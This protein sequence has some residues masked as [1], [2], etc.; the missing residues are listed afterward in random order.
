MRIRNDKDIVVAQRIRHARNN[1]E[2][3]KSLSVEDASNGWIWNVF[4]RAFH[5]NR[6][7]ARWSSWKEKFATSKREL[8]NTLWTSVAYIHAIVFPIEPDYPA[9]LCYVTA[10]RSRETSA[11]GKRLHARTGSR[12][13]VII[14]KASSGSSRAWRW[15]VVRMQIKVIYNGVIS[16]RW[17]AHDR[18]RGPRDATEQRGRGGDPIYRA[19]QDRSRPREYPVFMH[20]LYRVS[21]Q[22]PW[23]L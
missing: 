12:M 21:R 23:N 8:L 4:Q 2:L 10:R 19:A 1:K 14:S 18:D 15:N 16:V 20:V 7:R 6:S 13:W 22:V 9:N 17:A 5:A 3:T 11:R